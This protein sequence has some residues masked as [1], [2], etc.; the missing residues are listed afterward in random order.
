MAVFLAKGGKRKGPLTSDVEERKEHTLNV[1][2]GMMARLYRLE[3][4]ESG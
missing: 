4:N 2:D 3:H 1:V